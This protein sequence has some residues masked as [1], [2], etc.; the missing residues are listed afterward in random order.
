MKESYDQSLQL[1]TFLLAFSW[2]LHWKC[3]KWQTIEV[4][5]HCILILK[6]ILAW[7]Q[8]PRRSLLWIQLAVLTGKAAGDVTGSLCVLT[9]Q[10]WNDKMVSCEEASVSELSILFFCL[11]LISLGWW[12]LEILNSKESPQFLLPPVT[13]SS[14]PIDLLLRYQ[15]TKSF[16]A[17]KQFYVRAKKILPFPVLLLQ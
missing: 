13:H 12:G 10:G 4:T 6:N 3:L 16:L 1:G 14:S 5:I 8:C 11:H 17:Q 2:I 15:V 9:E 7:R